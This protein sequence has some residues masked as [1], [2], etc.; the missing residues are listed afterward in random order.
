MNSGIGWGMKDTPFKSGEMKDP[1]P[2]AF[3]HIQ[4]SNAA[5]EECDIGFGTQLQRCTQAGFTKWN[6]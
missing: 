1:F 2:A 4:P 6:L 3:G 5:S